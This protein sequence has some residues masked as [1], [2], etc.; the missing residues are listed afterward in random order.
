MGVNKQIKSK[1]WIGENF[2][3]KRPEETSWLL[4]QSTVRFT[5]KI[6]WNVSMLIYSDSRETFMTNTKNLRPSGP[7]IQIY[8]N[9]RINAME[10]KQT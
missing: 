5:I 2:A 6:R 3:N 1:Y 8:Y 7:S 4:K 9:L 10:R